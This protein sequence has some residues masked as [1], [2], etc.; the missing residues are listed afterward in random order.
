MMQCVSPSRSFLSWGLGLVLALG[1][2]GCVG[3]DG[4]GD[5]ASGS[6][7]SSSGSGGQ[8]Q[9]SGGGG[10]VPS[11]EYCSPTVGWPEAST[12]KELAM[13]ELVNAQR[14]QGANC[15]GE[16]FPA[17]D[18]FE[19][20]SSLWCAARVHTA[21][22]VENDYFSH[23]GLDGSSPRD[24]MDAA[25]FEGRGW[26]ENIAAGRSGAEET[27][28]QWM[29]SDGHCRNIMGDYRYFGVGY[30]AG[31]SRRHLWTQTFGR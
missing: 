5:S 13:L 19:M 4:D 27:L 9:G 31:S 10:E 28:E 6:G 3:D 1:A 26:A 2:L 17:R 24:R 8:T 21:D 7:G 15:G 16:S 29:A 22:M 20:D 18:P 30:V 11:G 12:S 14:A 25:G 23:T